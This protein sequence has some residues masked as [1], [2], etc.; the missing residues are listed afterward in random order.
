MNNSTTVES[1]ESFN[2]ALIL[3]TRYH[4]YLN[5]SLLFTLFQVPYKKEYR[6][7]FSLTH[8]HF[9]TSSLKTQ[10]QLTLLF[11]VLLMFSFQQFLLYPFMIFYFLLLLSWEFIWLIYFRVLYLCDIYFSYEATYNPTKFASISPMHPF[12]KYYFYACNQ[13][14]QFNS[15]LKL[16][17]DDYFLR[18]IN[19][20]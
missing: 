6:Y 19:R 14:S 12:S 1:Q 11:F 18:K 10:N 8:F 15:T 4:I 16:Y 3:K 7:K 5:K 13:I 2:K 20:I 9:S 17:K